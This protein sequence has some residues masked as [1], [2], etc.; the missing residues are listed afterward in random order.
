MGS[1]CSCNVGDQRTQGLFEQYN[2]ATGKVQ[3]SWDTPVLCL[4]TCELE[5]KWGESMTC[6]QPS[7]LPL[8]YIL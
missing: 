4:A 6:E 2:G 7:L 1:D 3:S 8:R 5:L